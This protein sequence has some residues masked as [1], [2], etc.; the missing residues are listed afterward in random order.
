[1]K[2]INVTKAKLEAVETEL[3]AVKLALEDPSNEKVTG[4][5]RKLTFEQLVKKEEQLLKKEEQLRAE[6]ILLLKKEE[7]LRE[8][9][10]LLLQLQLQQQQ[11]GAL[12][13]LAHL[14]HQP[15]PQASLAR[16]T[17]AAFVWQSLGRRFHRQC[18][19]HNF[20]ADM[21]GE[22]ARRAASALRSVAEPSTDGHDALKRV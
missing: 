19:E 1:M 20:M 17:R 3:A 11:S 6:K 13:S 9:K 7:Q 4:Y 12:P 22:R 8:E 10:N 21:R 2:E 16:W 5:L 14:R 18:C 15:H